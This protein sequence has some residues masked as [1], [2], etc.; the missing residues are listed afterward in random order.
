MNGL[1]LESAKLNQK[2]ETLQLIRAAIVLDE[3]TR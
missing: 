2:S 3:F 1:Q